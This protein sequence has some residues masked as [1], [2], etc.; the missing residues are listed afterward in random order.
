MKIKGII[1]QNILKIPDTTAPNI[2]AYSC[3]FW[4]KPES[5]SSDSSCKWNYG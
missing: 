1:V 3:I 4:T 2:T 5:I